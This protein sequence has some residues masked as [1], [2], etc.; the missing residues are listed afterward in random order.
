NEN[1]QIFESIDKKTEYLHQGMEKALSNNNVPH[2]IN[3]IG[4]M[5]SVHFSEEPV[6]D[7]DSSAKA[8]ATGK[9]NQFFHG[10]LENG[11]YIAPS[12]FETWF[13]TEALSYEDLD[14]TIEVVEKVA[15]E[16]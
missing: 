14:R 5:I 8:A 15:K 13:I 11:I 10:L 9:F 3:R 7:F 6:T 4:S 12:A 1:P 2:T 16:L